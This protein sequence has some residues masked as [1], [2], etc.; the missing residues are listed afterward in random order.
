MAVGMKNFRL[1]DKIKRKKIYGENFMTKR[2]YSL[3]VLRGLAISIML[4]LDGP[5][6]KIFS[7]LEHPAWAGLTI[8]DI[9]LPMF[10]FA[11][12]AGAAISMSKR[13]PP[14]KKILK[15][16]ALMFLIGV[17]LEM[18][19]FILLMIFDVD[20]TTADFFD[21][22][23]VHG[24]LFGIIQRLAITYALGIFIARAVK[25]NFG[26]LVAAFVLL[27]VSSAGYHIYAPDNPFDEA[28]NISQ[29]VDYI[30]P[31]V[32]HI[33]RPT[34]DPE[35][36]YG[37]LAGTASVLFGFIAGKIFVDQSSTVQQKISIF[38]KA[39]IILLIVGGVWSNFDII[40]KK[41]WTTPYALINAGLD[42]ILLALFMKIFDASPTAKK[43]SQPFGAL[44]IN[45]LF[46]FVMNNAILTLLYVLPDGKNFGGLY[47]QLYYNTTQGL[48]STEFGA[49]LFCAIWALMWLPICEF[50]YRRG[51]IIKI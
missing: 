50:F 34:H 26:I 43:F 18:E 48:I 1:C 38:C 15:R 46:F 47:L 30:F 10:A 24:R 45:P 8:P 39:G 21:K 7:I 35:G 5:P 49:T 28:H 42:F 27:I 23:F 16:T 12:G 22:V 36:L 9:A 29:A 13:E 44:G 6:D 25:N 37:C 19:P 11:M 41:L 3:D 2:I 17:L 14:V 40:T 32:N 4:F 51:I 20:F 31:G 33:Y